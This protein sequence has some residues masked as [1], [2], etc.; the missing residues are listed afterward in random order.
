MY[1]VSHVFTEPLNVGV[2]YI[3]DDWHSA[4]ETAIQRVVSLENKKPDQPSDLQQIQDELESDNN[5][6]DAS[7]LF[8]VFI[9]QPE[10]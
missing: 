1:I 10:E 2:Q 7:G 9:T 3:R 6:M 5:W 4:L 8:G